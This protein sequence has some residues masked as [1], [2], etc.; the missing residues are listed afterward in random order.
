[1]GAISKINEYIERKSTLKK[2]V[3]LFK[4]PGFSDIIK[5][6][7]TKDF[8]N[9]AIAGLEAAPL[10]F[11]IMPAAM[12]K[13]VHHKSEHGIGE[14]EKDDINQIHRVGK[15]GGK[16]FHTLRVLDVAEIFIEA[17]D[18]RVKNY[19]GS[20]KSMKYGNEMTPRERD[21]IRT[22]CLWHDIYSGGTGDEFNSKRR[23]M[24]KNH[25]HY[26]RK[27]LASLCHYVS[28]DE[29]DLLLMAIEQH[30]WKWDDNIDILKFHDIG[31]QNTVKDAHAYANIYRIVRIV[32]LSDLIASRNIRT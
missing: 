31:K 11:W 16:A 19:N 21:L 7:E 27:E 4:V 12:R 32:E 26:H 15:I 3:D 5:N 30:M 6:F 8:K 14:V 17:D 20:I 13:G 1:M 25:P 28:V 23:G 18:P 2:K 29:W 24:D 10:Q 22:A 9:L